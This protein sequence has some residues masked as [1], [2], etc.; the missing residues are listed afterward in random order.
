MHNECNEFQEECENH[1]NELFGKAPGDAVAM[2]SMQLVDTAGKFTRF[3]AG[4]IA[5]KALSHAS[6]THCAQCPVLKSIINDCYDLI[7]QTQLVPGVPN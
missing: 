6:G 7:E 1:L 5:V 4:N 2:A 3:A